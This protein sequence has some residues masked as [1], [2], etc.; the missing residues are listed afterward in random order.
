M[1]YHAIACA[2]EGFSYNVLFSIFSSNHSYIIFLRHIEK[3]RPVIA[4]KFIL[5]LG[6]DE[7]RNRRKWLGPIRQFLSETRS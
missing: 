5:E 6:V 1:Q 3:A 4:N 7:T 2:T